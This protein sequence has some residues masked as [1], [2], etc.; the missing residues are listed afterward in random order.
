MW[1]NDKIWK[2]LPSSLVAW[3]YFEAEAARG[4]LDS[5]PSPPLIGG[6]GGRLCN[7]TIK[8]EKIGL[9]IVYYDYV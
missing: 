9:K 1:I 5:S 8:V 3:M 2:K 6:N 4:N 7:I